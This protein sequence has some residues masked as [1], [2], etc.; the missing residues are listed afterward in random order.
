DHAVALARAERGFLLLRERAGGELRIRVARNIDQETIRNKAFKISRS[1]AEEVM[2]R[3][4]A[5]VTVDAMADERFAAQLSVHELRLRSVL[6]VPLTIRRE[7][8]GAIYLDNRFRSEA[9][10]RDERDL[11]EALADQAALA[12]GNW[13]LVDENRRR[14]VDLE[15]LNVDLEGANTRLEVIAAAQREQLS[16]LSELTR[17]Q[18]DELAGRYRFDNLIGRSAGMQKLFALMGRVKDSDA[19]VLIQGES[20]TGKEVVARALHYAGARRE[21]P[22]VGV[23]CGALPGTLLD[24]ELFGYVRGAFT[25]AERDRRGVIERANGGTLFLDEVG[26]MPPELQV[27][28]LRVLQERRFERIGSEEEIASDFRLIAASNKDLRNLVASGE[29]REDLFYRINVL[30]LDLPPLRERR[31]DI[32][33]LVDFLLKRHDA[34]A[35]KLSRAA[36]DL[37]IAYRW[38]GNVRE[39]ENEVLRVLALG[40]DV[41]VPDDLSPP[42]RQATARPMIFG[43]ETLKEAL[44]VTEEEIVRAR[45]AEYHGNVTEAAKSLGMTRV[46]LHKLLKRHGI[47]ASTLR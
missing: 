12:L 34:S 41:I 2:A 37:L 3:G 11:M 10:A 18:R 14:Q 22:F 28:L 1:I 43:G 15:R 38:P 42:L 16:E 26:D 20:G 30:R 46:G 45:L 44:F 5:I 27:K 6:C 21:G 24:S 4:Q 29:L 17:N 35:V 19:S 32:S 40:G 7:L 39:L 33:L 25:G 23:N 9:F 47:D 8:R 31:D 13:E 36:L